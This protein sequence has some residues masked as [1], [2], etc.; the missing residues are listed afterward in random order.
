MVLIGVCLAVFGPA[1]LGIDWRRGW[2]NASGWW[3]SEWRE[4]SNVSACDTA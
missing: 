1:V 2:I 3:V 4:N